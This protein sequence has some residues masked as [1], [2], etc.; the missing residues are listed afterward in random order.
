MRAAWHSLTV[1]SVGSPGAEAVDHVGWRLRAA[2]RVAAAYGLSPNLAVLAVAGSVGAGFAD[3]WS[4][5]EVDCYWWEPPSEDD[6]RTPISVLGADLKAFWDYDE[7]D[8]EWSEDYSS[9]RFP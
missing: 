9:G 7:D 6:R 4:D 5:L 1:A 2:E 8:E 3:R